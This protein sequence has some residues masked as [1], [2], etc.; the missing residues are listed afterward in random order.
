MY[1]GQVVEQADAESMFTRT[2]HPYTA[3][4]LAANPHLAEPGGILTTI[5]GSV[6]DPHDWPDGCRFAPRCALASPACSQAPIELTQ[7]VPDRAT[8]CLRADELLLE[9]ERR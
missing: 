8:R 3:G 5:P 4:L 7:P 9:G 6:P 2:L 1:A